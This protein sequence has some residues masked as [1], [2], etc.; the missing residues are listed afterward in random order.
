MEYG[1]DVSNRLSYLVN[2][3]F[4]MDARSEIRVQLSAWEPDAGPTRTISSRAQAQGP[5]WETH[6][7]AQQ[8][9]AQA[10]AAHVD[11]AA[12]MFGRATPPRMGPA[13][14]SAH[15]LGPDVPEHTKWR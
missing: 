1:K 10:A 6:H 11:G 2:S 12:A 7:L 9:S 3:F 5:S 8:W 4:I 13:L 14:T 15:W